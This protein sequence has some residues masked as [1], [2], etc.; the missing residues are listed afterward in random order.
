MPDSHSR[1]LGWHEATLGALR[2]NMPH[3]LLLEVPDSEP[4]ASALL[5]AWLAALAIGGENDRAT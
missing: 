4:G 3:G 1:A 2:R 5:Y